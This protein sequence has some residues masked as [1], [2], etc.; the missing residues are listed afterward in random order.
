MPKIYSLLLIAIFAVSCKEEK[1]LKETPPIL[2]IQQKTEQPSDTINYFLRVESPRPG[3]WI[4]SPLKITGDA[5]GSWFFEAEAKTALLDGNRQKIS[6]TTITAIGD[7]MT[8][9]WVPFSGSMT[10]E[11]PATENG[12]LVFNKANASGLKDHELSD[13]IPVKFRMQDQP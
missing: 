8:E 9:D 4:T 7:W 10:F 1:S 13:T 12:F 6:Q 3:Q 2:E 11:K 5:R